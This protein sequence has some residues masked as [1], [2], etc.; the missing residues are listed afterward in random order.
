MHKDKKALFQALN[1]YFGLRT[2]SELWFILM[3]FDR[4]AETSSFKEFIK[5]YK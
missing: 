4:N 2:I 1:Q 5:N 3:E